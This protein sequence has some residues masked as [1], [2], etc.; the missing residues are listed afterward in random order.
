[1]GK[2][3]TVIVFARLQTKEK[4]IEVRVLF[5]LF[6][7]DFTY[8]PITIPEAH[9]YFLKILH[10]TFSSDIILCLFLIGIYY[11]G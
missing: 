3:G 8:G 9:F 7:L 10:G 4:N 2:I 11:E 6:F 5:F 1:M